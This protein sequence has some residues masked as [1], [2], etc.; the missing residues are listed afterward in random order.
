MV[1]SH[2]YSTHCISVYTSVV[3]LQACGEI[4]GFSSFLECFPSPP[5]PFFPLSPSLLPASPSLPSLSS[6]HMDYDSFM[7]NAMA[8]RDP[9]HLWD[10]SDYP[11]PQ[12]DMAGFLS[13]CG[14][15]MEDYTASLYV[16]NR[17]LVERGKVVPLASH[18][19][20]LYSRSTLNSV[21]KMCCVL[22]A[23]MYFVL[24]IACYDVL[25]AI[26]SLFCTVLYHCAVLYC[27]V[28]HHCAVLYC[29]VLHRAVLHCTVLHH[30]A[31]LY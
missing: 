24:C 27:T 7:N 21:C 17:E 16:L 2:I 6:D 23:V 5:S 26:L 13:Y 31:V 14:E 18:G 15:S 4:T 11:D 19:P 8:F 25:C 20:I 29:T 3:V 10:G 1:L 12:L 9:A 28:L 22:C 30:C